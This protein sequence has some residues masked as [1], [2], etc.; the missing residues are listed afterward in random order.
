MDPYDQLIRCTGFQ[1]DDG[2]LLKTWERHG[3]LANESEQVFFNRPLIVAADEKHSS[4]ES[5]YYA[6][7]HTDTGRLLFVV[8]T[9]RGELVRVISSRDM[10]RR[11]R[12]IYEES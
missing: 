9:I 3:V 1:W 6:L 8:F 11:E 12:R 5:R 2:N 10:N 4:V 7:G